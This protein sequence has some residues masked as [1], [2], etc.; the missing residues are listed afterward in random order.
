LIY[1]V[2]GGALVAGVTTAVWRRTAPV[3]TAFVL[4]LLALTTMFTGLH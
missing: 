4:L 3:E 1:V 2:V